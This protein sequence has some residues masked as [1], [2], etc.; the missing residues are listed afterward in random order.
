MIVYVGV[1]CLTLGAV[2]GFVLC[3]LFS[4]NGG[5]DDG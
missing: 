4:A 3:A 1:C 2:I 5:D